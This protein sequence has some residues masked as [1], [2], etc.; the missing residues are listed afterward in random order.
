[1]PAYVSHTRVIALGG[2]CVCICV[3]MSVWDAITH[4]CVC[5]HICVCTWMPEE[6]IGC[7]DLTLSTLLLGDRVSCCPCGEAGIQQAPV[8]L[9]SLP[10]TVEVIDMHTTKA[11]FLYVGL[12]DLNSG[13]QTFAASTITC[14]DISQL[15]ESCFHSNRRLPCQTALGLGSSE[16]CSLSP[17]SRKI[18]SFSK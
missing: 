7:P 4:E 2:C 6:D 5:A 15:P 12:G 16:V 18:L 17:T 9:L 13:P 3:Y 14:G 10:S 11:S 8:I 1:M